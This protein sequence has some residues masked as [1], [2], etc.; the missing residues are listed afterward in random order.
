VNGYTTILG[1]LNIS[2]SAADPQSPMGPSQNGFWGPG[3]HIAK[4]VNYQGNP[5]LWYAPDYWLTVDGTQNFS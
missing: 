2:N 4:N 5:G 1:N 3:N